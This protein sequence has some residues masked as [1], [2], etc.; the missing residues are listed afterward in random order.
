MATNI[1]G[2]AKHDS[3]KRRNPEEYTK[4]FELNEIKPLD[5]DTEAQTDVAV[6]AP[7]DEILVNNGK[8]TKKSNYVKSE[9]LATLKRLKLCL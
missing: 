5:T 1:N 4:K 3:G 9:C 7:N 6:T 2:D 8:S